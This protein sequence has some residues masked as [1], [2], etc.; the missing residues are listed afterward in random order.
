MSAYDEMVTATFNGYLPIALPDEV[1]P[2]GVP[3]F[4]IAVA[5]QDGAVKAHLT[6]LFS[7]S[8]LLR[9]CALVGLAVGAHQSW[10]ALQAQNE[11]KE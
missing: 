7:D 5:E 10:H 9:A 11:G 3:V 2:E 8:P 6:H 1:M 4:T